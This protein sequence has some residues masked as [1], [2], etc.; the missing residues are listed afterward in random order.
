MSAFFFGDI[1]IAMRHKRIAFVDL[2]T[3]DLWFMKSSNAKRH[4]KVIVSLFFSSIKA[5][6]IIYDKNVVWAN[7]KVGYTFQVW[8]ELY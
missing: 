6:D 2:I 3:H 7:I 5:V 8:E 1:I 4:H